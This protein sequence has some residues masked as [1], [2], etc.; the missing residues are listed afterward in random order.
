MRVKSLNALRAY[1]RKMVSEEEKLPEFILDELR[2]EIG[3]CLVRVDQL[4]AGGDGIFTIPVYEDQIK[5][6][7]KI[8]V[9]QGME[10]DVGYE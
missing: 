8:L 2:R 1:W 5:K 10:G 9:S 3:F 7:R 6:M 4:K